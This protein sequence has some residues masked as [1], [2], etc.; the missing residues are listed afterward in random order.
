VYN[1]WKLSSKM[2]IL[3]ITNHNI[4]YNKSDFILYIEFQLLLSLNLSLVL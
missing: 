4:S 2:E 3:V 1:L